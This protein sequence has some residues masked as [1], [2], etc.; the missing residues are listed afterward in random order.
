MTWQRLV[1]VW[2]LRFYKEA[3]SPVL[4]K[5][6]ELSEEVT[7]NMQLHERIRFMLE[8]L[9]LKLNAN[10]ISW[11]EW[12]ACIHCESLWCIVM[13]CVRPWNVPILFAVESCHPTNRRDAGLPAR[14]DDSCSKVKELETN[15]G[16]ERKMN[17]KLMQ[18]EW[19]WLCMIK[20]CDYNVWVQH[21]YSMIGKACCSLQ[22][23]AW[24]C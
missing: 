20:V 9:C 17:G 5:L 8:W 4:Q 19:T 16:N 21:D 2:Q 12:N 13:H 3:N 18:N 10:G 24:T 11:N 15:I 22:L 1:S 7:G 14:R 6:K 23:A